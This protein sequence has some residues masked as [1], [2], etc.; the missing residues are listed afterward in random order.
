MGNSNGED[1]DTREVVDKISLIDKEVIKFSTIFLY[2]F[3]YQGNK[4][5]VIHKLKSEGNWES[6]IYQY[7]KYYDEYVYFHPFTR[8]ILFDQSNI[9][10]E[11][12]MVYLY[13]KKSKELKL[14]VTYKEKGNKGFHEIEKF[15]PINSIQLH[16]FDLNVGIL[17]IQ[18][19]TAKTLKFREILQFNELVRRIAPSWQGQ[20]DIGHLPQKVE[21][22]DLNG[23]TIVE[24]VEDFNEQEMI[25]RPRDGVVYVSKLIQ[26]L[27]SPL[28]ND[29]KA[30]LSKTDQTELRYQTALDERMVVY[31]YVCF[32]DKVQASEIILSDDDFLAFVLVDREP[33]G[34]FSNKSMTKKYLKQYKYNRWEDLGTRYGFSRYSGVVLGKDDP[35]IEDGKEIH[36]FRDKIFKDFKTI[37]YQIALILYFHR[38]ALLKFS[39]ESSLCSEILSRSQ[40]NIK[41]VNDLRKDFLV[42]TNKFWFTEITNQDQGIE[43]FDQWEGILRNKELFDEV[44][45]ELKEINEF[46]EREQ[47]KNSADEMHQLEKRVGTLTIITIIFLPI[48]LLTSILGMNPLVDISKWW[49]F[50][51]IFP[52]FW[53]LTFVLV[54]NH[55]IINWVDESLFI[56][57]MGFWGKI[58]KSFSLL[59][60][61]L[62]VLFGR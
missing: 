27:M 11:K 21:F 35:W 40:N 43:M 36:F 25:Q 12:S 51:L 24:S 1:K 7:E 62:N 56:N 42:F 58:K 15:Y 34:S 60:N 53:L 22:I 23:H 16:L 47:D 13:F 33:G 48:M 44:A 52:S 3:Y 45:Y 4:E 49:I 17:T 26:H 9:D 46:I 50:I 54:K 8:D 38:A 57:K 19:Q 5:S 18:I 14:K 41:Q 55:E 31:S 20:K 39:H 30:D 37:Y 10:Y 59:R 32:D 61:L 2:P 28:K 6:P 29:K